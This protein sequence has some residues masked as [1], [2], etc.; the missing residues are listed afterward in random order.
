M[1]PNQ[2]RYN[3]AYRQVNVTVAAP[4]RAFPTNVKNGPQ[5]GQAHSLTSLQHSNFGTLCLYP[6]F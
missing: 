3:V 6:L 5:H 2:S 4:L 1:A